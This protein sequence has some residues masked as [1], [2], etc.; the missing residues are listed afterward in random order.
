MGHYCSILVAYV[1]LSITKADFSRGTPDLNTC[2][3]HEAIDQNSTRAA[4]EQ[5]LMSHLVFYSI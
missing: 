1:E 2:L 5:Q 3:N 4:N